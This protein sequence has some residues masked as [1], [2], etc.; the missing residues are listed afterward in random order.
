MSDTPNESKDF[1]QSG[2][3]REWAK[4]FVLAVKSNA[5]I[6]SD[7]GTMIGWFANALMRGYDTARQRYEKPPCGKGTKR[8]DPVAPSDVPIEY[9]Y[10]QPQELWETFDRGQQ[11]G[12]V[13]SDALAE[14]GDEDLTTLDIINLRAVRGFPNNRPILIVEPVRL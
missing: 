7:E 8:F 13:V 4:A 9:R 2:D 3:A 10:N 11:Y 12:W 6:A 1:T 5:G 14:Y